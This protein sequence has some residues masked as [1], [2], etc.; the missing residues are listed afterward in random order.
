M[1]DQGLVD[2]AR[3][4]LASRWPDAGWGVAAAVYLDGGEI[5]TSVG[6]D[7]LNSGASLCAEAGALCQAYTMNR[8]VVASVC[9]CRDEDGAVSVLAPCGICQERLA[10]WGPDVQVAVADP[11]RPG[12]WSSRSLREL[13]PFYWGTR[14]ADDG[15][16][17]SARTHRS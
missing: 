1:V 13:H 14:F 7:N 16:W 2:A 15:G 3:H 4:Q 6:L 10:L 11:D 8:Q 5:V 9:V 17:P 12:G